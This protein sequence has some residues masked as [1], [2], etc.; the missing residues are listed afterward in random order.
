MPASAS[1]QEIKPVRAPIVL[2]D[3]DHPTGYDPLT[4]NR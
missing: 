2:V 3:A 1:R 4:L